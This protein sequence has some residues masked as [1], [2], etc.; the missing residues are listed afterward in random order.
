MADLKSFTFNGALG[1][2]TAI[3]K[4]SKLTTEIRLFANDGSALVVDMYDETP[5]TKDNNDAGVYLESSSGERSKLDITREDEFQIAKLAGA[6]ALGYVTYDQKVEE[7]PRTTW[8]T[9]NRIPLPL[10]MNVVDVNRDG[11]FNGND[12][13]AAVAKAAEKQNGSAR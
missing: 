1:V 8:T 9:A 5:A 13:V 3:I 4:D 11:A 6:L 12:V 7:T 10:D 2:N